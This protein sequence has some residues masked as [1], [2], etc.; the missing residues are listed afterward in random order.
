MPQAAIGGSPRTFGLTLPA[1]AA[2]DIRKSSFAT[3]NSTSAYDED[4][5]NEAQWQ[6]VAALTGE[7]FRLPAASVDFG[8]HRF[9]PFVFDMTVLDPGVVSRDQGLAAAARLRSALR[10]NVRNN[11]TVRV[12]VQPLTPLDEIFVWLEIDRYRIAEFLGKVQMERYESLEE[13]VAVTWGA[14]G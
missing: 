5:S 6:R 10:V 7:A 3:V 9:D 8:S 1:L 4:W 2:H 11:W 14:Q 12:W 13:F